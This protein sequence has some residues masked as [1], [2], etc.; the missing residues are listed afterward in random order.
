MF[1]SGTLGRLPAQGLVNARLSLNNDKYR[2]EVA[3][4]VKNLGDK[5]YVVCRT[6]A[7][8]VGFVNE[9]VAAPRTYGV[10]VTKRF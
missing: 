9:I 7:S 4:F 3:G 6:D 2:L 1:T 5:R 10:E 8:S